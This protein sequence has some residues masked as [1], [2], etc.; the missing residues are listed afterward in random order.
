MGFLVVFELQIMNVQ[1]VVALQIDIHAR[2]YV[3]TAP[4]WREIR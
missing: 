1:P 3:A 2:L 4:F